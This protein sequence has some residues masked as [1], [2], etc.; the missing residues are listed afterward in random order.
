MAPR[1]V[2][3]AVAGEL[4][5][6]LRL[7]LHER[8]VRR[9]PRRSAGRPIASRTA[10]S[11]CVPC[12][13]SESALITCGKYAFAAV[14]M[15][16]RLGRPHCS[17]LP[18]PSHGRAPRHEPSGFILELGR[19]VPCAATC[20]TRSAPRGR[21][22]RRRCR[23]RRA[24]AAACTHPPSRGR[25]SASRGRETWPRGHARTKR[26][27]TTWRPSN[28][29]FSSS[30]F[31]CTSRRER[32]STVACRVLLDEHPLREA[33]DADRRALVP[34]APSRRRAARRGAGPGHR[35]ISEILRVRRG[36][37]IS[38]SSSTFGHVSSPPTIPECLGKSMSAPGPQVVIAWLRRICAVCARAHGSSVEPVAAQVLEEQVDAWL[39]IA[40]RAV[41]RGT[42]GGARTRSRCRASPASAASAC[43]ARSA[44]TAA[45]I[46]LR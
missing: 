36:S 2:L 23:A 14:R 6:D 24:T 19:L 39:D 8:Q 28:V 17:W 44:G 3:V 13:G 35:S 34:G 21:R 5:R 43:P 27:G 46:P 31:R 30:D 18:A 37:T 16:S 42:C 40:E 26:V 29:P 9:C 7:L 38:S 10:S 1:I 12:S 33:P 25:T 11:S 4:G 22:G 41:R 15:S 32:S 45:G 20:R